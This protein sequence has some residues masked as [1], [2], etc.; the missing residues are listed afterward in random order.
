MTYIQ[1]MTMYVRR[2]FLYPLVFIPMATTLG[3]VQKKLVTP[4]T[5]SFV[6]KLFA[7]CYK[8]TSLIN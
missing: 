5:G 6:F 7:N 8:S 3:P 2:H 1:D 4:F